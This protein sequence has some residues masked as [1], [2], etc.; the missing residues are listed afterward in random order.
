MKDE[1][2]MGMSAKYT[3][4]GK[5]FENEDISVIGCINKYQ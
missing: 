3:V 1:V 4:V 2:D 5:V